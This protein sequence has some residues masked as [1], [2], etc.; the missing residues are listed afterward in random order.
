MKT[1]EIEA[2]IV[3]SPLAQGEFDY[4]S[5]T[6]YTL[7]FNP[8][9]TQE[10]WLGE[11]KR[12]FDTYESILEGRRR[13]LCY[14]ADGLRFG[15]AKWP[16]EY[17]QAIETAAA[18]LNVEQKTVQNLVA[19]YEH[20]PE[21]ARQLEVSDSHMAVVAIKGVP[22]AGKIELLTMAKE[23]KLSVA[24]FK[25]KANE[26]MVE[27]GWKKAPK[28]KKTNP[29]GKPV[30]KVVV[31]VNDFEGMLHMINTVATFLNDPERFARDSWNLDTLAKWE[32]GLKDIARATKRLVGNGGHA[33]PQ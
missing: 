16:E 21:A 20:M 26:I 27:S 18:W 24:D 15:A 5:K 14:L 8:S 30:E 6:Q 31:D 29:D 17:A 22:D 25:K 3:V 9:V 28:A 10:A 19:I 4:G 11:M 12:L 1:T 7:T 13:I 2:E 33:K 23:E 32:P